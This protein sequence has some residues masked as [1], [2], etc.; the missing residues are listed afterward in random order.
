MRFYNVGSSPIFR[1]LKVLKNWGFEALIFLG[2]QKSNQT[3][4][5]NNTKGEILNG[6]SPCGM[7]EYCAFLNMLFV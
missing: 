6:V 3:G 2:N 4:N 1:S 5:Q 7:C